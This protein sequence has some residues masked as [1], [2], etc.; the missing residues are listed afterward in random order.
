M[1]EVTEE[2]LKMDEREFNNPWS[3]QDKASVL[4]ES[5]CFSDAPI[6]SLKC[7][8]LLTRIIYLIQYLGELA[9]HTSW[10]L[11]TM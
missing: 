8:N 9:T 4:Q 7:Q 6:D 2:N 11:N 5:R 10:D 1:L 3:T